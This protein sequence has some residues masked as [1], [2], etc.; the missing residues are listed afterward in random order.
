MEPELWV[1]LTAV[2]LP[3]AAAVVTPLFYRI[4]DERVGYFG[5]V[6][7]VVSFTL[8]GSQVGTTGIVSLPWMPSLDIAV[9]FYIDGWALMFALLAS[10]IGVV[11][12]VY[13]STYMEGKPSIGRFYATLLAFMGSIL[14][15]AFAG[16]LILLFL[17]WELTSVC[18]FV[19]IG[20][21]TEDD[22][23]R[24]SARMAMV[25][26]SLIGILFLFLTVPTGAHIISRAA[27]KIG[28][29]FLGGVTWSSKRREDK[30]VKEDEEASRQDEK[31]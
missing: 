17:F 3:F 23:S 12:F 6:I 5:A 8:I 27:Q 28:V 7:A 11:I 24:Y 9:T 15:V 18:S 22:E 1:V 21:Y 14:G 25:V 26:T 19:L 29:P 20:Y 4:L 13:S 10:G 31:D 16:D 2:F 30:S